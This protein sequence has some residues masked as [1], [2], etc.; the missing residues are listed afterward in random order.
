MTEIPALALLAGGIW[1]WA[2]SAPVQNR[3]RGGVGRRSCS[4][5]VP[6]AARR[7][8]HA[9]APSPCW[10][11]GWSRPGRFDRAAAALAIA[12]LVTAVVAFL[13]VG[14]FAWSYFA[15]NWD[16]HAHAVALRRAAGGRSCWRWSPLLAARRRRAVDGFLDRHTTRDRDRES[17]SSRPAASR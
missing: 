5:Y 7:A 2:V 3:V 10:R 13:H 9:S 8:V 1:L 11:C 6:D 4:G 16:R 15:S 17:R 12:T 14:R